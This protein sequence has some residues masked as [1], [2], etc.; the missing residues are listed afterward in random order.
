MFQVKFN[1]QVMSFDAPI[2]VYDA[3]KE[4]GLISREIIAAAVNGTTTD[5]TTLITADA[6]VAHCNRIS[7]SRCFLP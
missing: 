4:A 5:L 3:A 6:E 7:Q 1:E 2:T